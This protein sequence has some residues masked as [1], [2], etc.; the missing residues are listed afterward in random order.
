MSGGT[1]KIIRMQISNFSLTVL[2]V[3]HGPF[4]CGT[5]LCLFL[6][7]F[8]LALPLGTSRDD[9]GGAGLG[10]HRAIKVSH[11]GVGNYSFH[12]VITSFSLKY[13]CF[14]VGVIAYRFLRRSERPR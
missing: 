10:S 2:V 1:D 13:I 11:F 12:F 8:F 3:L 14:P 9:A 5:R 4:P 7:A 6:S